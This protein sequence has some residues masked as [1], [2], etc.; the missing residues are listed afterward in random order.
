MVADPDSGSEQLE[1]LA[2]DR[3]QIR[4]AGQIPVG[5]GQ[6][7]VADIGRE[8]RHGVADIGAV[9]MPKLDATADEGV[10][11]IVNA[12]LGVGAARRPAE[13]ASQPLEHP[14]DGPLR[15]QPPDD[16]RNSNESRLAAP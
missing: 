10:A 14:M 6:L 4:D 16:D 5:I 13:F 3:H 7:R 15:Q 2:D 8:C 12:R 1:A 11:Q 9:L